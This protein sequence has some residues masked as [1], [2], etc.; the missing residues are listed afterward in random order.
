MRD[1]NVVTLIGRLTRDAEA[2]QGNGPVRLSIAVNRTRKE[3][4][5]YVD[6]ASFV[7]LEYWHKSL[8]PYLVKGKQIAVQGEIRQERWTDRETGA[9]RSKLVVVVNDKAGIQLLGSKEGQGEARGG[10]DGANSAR[11][12]G[13]AK[14][15]GNSA[16]QR[17]SQGPAAD[18]FT[19]DIPF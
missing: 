11:G 2:P 13:D 9:A 15:A 14:S 1:L 5:Q 10:S 7:D 3:G 4:D 16:S 12:E 18:D 19:D 17:A 8:T 6:E